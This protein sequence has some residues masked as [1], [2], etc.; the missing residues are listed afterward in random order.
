MNSREFES[1][2]SQLAGRFNL[3]LHLRFLACLAAALLAANRCVYVCEQVYDERRLH[4]HDAGKAHD[5]QWWTK[6]SGATNDAAE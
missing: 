1:R 6:Q 5:R 3:L 4:E 2:D